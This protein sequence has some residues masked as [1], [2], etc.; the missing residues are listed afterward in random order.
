MQRD[1]KF[2]NNKDKFFGT[3]KQIPLKAGGPKSTTSKANSK[4]SDA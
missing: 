4:I 1:P 2:I 3:Q